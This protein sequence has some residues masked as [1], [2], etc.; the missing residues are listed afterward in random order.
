MISSKKQSKEAD[1]GEINKRNEKRR[2]EKITEAVI[3][4]IVK[5]VAIAAVSELVV[6]RREFLETLRSDAGEVS[7]E[8]GVIS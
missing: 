3:D 1:Q 2:R 8:L 4:E 5:G 6:G 7:G